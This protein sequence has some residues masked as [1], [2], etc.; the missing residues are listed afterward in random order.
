M[1]F[2]RLPELQKRPNTTAVRTINKGVFMATS[3]LRA[4]R[5]YPIVQIIVVQMNPRRTR[6]TVRP[7]TP[8]AL[9][10]VSVRAL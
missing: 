1:N 10:P 9:Y 6:A 3:L 4:P 8:F 2:A 5:T 7:T